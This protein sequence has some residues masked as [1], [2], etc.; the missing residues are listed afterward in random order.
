LN[1]KCQE[2][3]K[4]ENEIIN[5]P[6]VTTEC[7]AERFVPSVNTALNHN[8]KL[9]VVLLLTLAKYNGITQCHEKFKIA[10]AHIA[11]SAIT[12]FLVLF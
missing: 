7:V 10:E 6:L 2:S 3:K 11:Y 5:G 9:T 1:P 8:S 4:K 12:F